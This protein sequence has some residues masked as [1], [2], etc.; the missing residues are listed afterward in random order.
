MYL[1]RVGI[2]IKISLLCF[3]FIQLPNMAS[4]NRQPRFD[5]IYLIF[6][7][8]QIP[9][10]IIM[11]MNQVTSVSELFW[12]F[13]PHIDPNEVLEYYNSNDEQSMAF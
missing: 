9:L 6:V 3:N 12:K 5:K 10:N 4:Q 11:E 13:M 7:V 1:R 8:F 2:K